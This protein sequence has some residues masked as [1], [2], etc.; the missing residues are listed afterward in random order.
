MCRA[1][2]R[3]PDFVLPLVGFRQQGPNSSMNEANT[4]RQLPSIAVSVQTA[5]IKYF[6]HVAVVLL[7]SPRS[8]RNSPSDF[9][10]LGDKRREAFHQNPGNE[11]DQHEV[12][13]SVKGMNPWA[14]GVVVEP[15][16]FFKI[17]EE[18]PQYPRRIAKKVVPMLYAGLDEPVQVGGRQRGEFLHHRVE[19]GVADGGV[20]D[21]VVC[22]RLVENAGLDVSLAGTPKDCVPSLNTLTS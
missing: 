10:R 7:E 19:H 2:R 6:H 21:I 1:Y 4:G 5:G 16:R 22:R 17:V 8:R 20:L 12:D 15:G 18:I 9:E 14:K 11:S 3:A 13:V